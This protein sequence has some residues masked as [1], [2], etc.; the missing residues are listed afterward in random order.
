MSAILGAF[1][2]AADLADGEVQRILRTMQVRG[3]DRTEI[4]RDHGAVLAVAR[5]DWELRAPFSGPTLVA[6]D[7]HCIV[8]ADASLYYRDDLVR[9]LAEA[10]VMPTGRT[11]SHLILAAYAAWGEELAA[12]IEGDFAFIVWDR[13]SRRM[14]AARDFSG[15]RPLHYARI[16]GGLVAASTLGGV[17]H[18]PDCSADLD[19]AHLA[20][21]AAGLFFAAGPDTCY[22]AIRVLPS[23]HTLAWDAAHAAA[24][25]VRHWDPLAV[26]SDTRSITGVE[27]AEEL[28]HMLRRAAVERMPDGAVTAVW[29]SGGLDS[30][31]VFAAAQEARRLAVS[32]LP[33]PAVSI[34]SADGRAAHDDRLVAAAARF[35]HTAVHWID[36]GEVPLVDQP[37]LGAA[38][39]DQPYTHLYEQLNRAL[40]RGA[41]DCGARVVLDGSGGDQV[42]RNT[43]I[44]LADLA[45]SGRWLQLAREWRD[46]R[47][48]GVRE[49]VATAVQPN[50]RGSMA[51]IAARAGHAPRHYLERM[52]PSWI[53]DG[54][55]RRHGLAE[56]DL[57]HLGRDEAPSH[58]LR[59]MDWM[60]GNAFIVRA[61]AHLAEYALDAGMELRSPLGDRRIVEFAFGRPWW[62]RSSGRESKLLLRDAVRGSLPDAILA[63][64]PERSG[65]TAGYSQRWMRDAF[66]ALLESTLRRPLVLEQLGIVRAAALRDAADRY[67]RT[68]DAWTRVNLYYTLQTEL[69]LRSHT[70]TAPAAEAL[71]DVAAAPA[72][73]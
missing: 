13:R 63:P 23:A 15:R 58:A 51:W 66:P 12:R 56:R 6:Q 60:L 71:A 65:V 67:P 32:G 68:G 39:R 20:G 55:A 45:R 3:A 40:A 19:V 2:P 18:H 37:E 16:R 49:F 7:E 69:W 5:H 57:E 35:W 27:A 42:F 26:E 44:V 14:V 24:E 38:L 53:D 30:T 4:V 8:A 36:A 11:P 28:R 31:A 33:V 34:G 46:R 43:H 29:T 70:Q 61:F 50:L 25:P 48:G 1:G 47:A 9:A 21:T 72:P 73:G 54:F 41:R 62:E 10:G 64:R 22:A 52:M 17:L 59:E